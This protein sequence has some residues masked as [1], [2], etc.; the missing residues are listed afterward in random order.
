M[1]FIPPYS[2]TVTGYIWNS[3][4]VGDV[5]RY[6]CYGNMACGVMT[7]MPSREWGGGGGE[8]RGEGRERKGGKRVGMR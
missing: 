5:A 7:H 3:Q 2:E 6:D 4:W 1:L 8:G